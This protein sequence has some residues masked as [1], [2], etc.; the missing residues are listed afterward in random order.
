M[1][2]NTRI[3]LLKKEKKVLEQLISFSSAAESLVDSS[4]ANFVV[5]LY[6]FSN[7][8]NEYLLSEQSAELAKNDFLAADKYKLNIDN[9]ANERS[10]LFS[11]VVPLLKSYIVDNKSD[12][13]IS[14]KLYDNFLRVV[15]TNA[16]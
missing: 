3:D 2:K 15:N 10:N 12:F 6:C 4:F 14:S 1:I 16:D 8:P 5:E 7:A 9:L 13:P 11:S